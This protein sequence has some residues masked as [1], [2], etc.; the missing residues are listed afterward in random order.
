MYNTLL[1]DQETINKYYIEAM[2]SRRLMLAALIIVTISMMSSVQGGPL[3]YA[4]CQKG[5]AG[6]VVAC[7]SAAGVAFG[8]VPGAVIAA[9]PALAGCNSAYAACYTTCSVLIIAPT[10]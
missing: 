5:C 9:S 3:S 6:L 1:A 2:A 7:F 8:A 10:P 4:A